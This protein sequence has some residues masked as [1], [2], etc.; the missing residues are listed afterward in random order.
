MNFII[1]MK[2][3]MT[4]SFRLGIMVGIQLYM[5][6][7]HILVAIKIVDALYISKTKLAQYLIN[8]INIAY[9]QH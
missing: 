6:V 7:H 5:R 9:V 2:D 8:I 1:K 3:G 4:F